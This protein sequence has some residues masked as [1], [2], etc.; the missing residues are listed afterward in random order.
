MVVALFGLVLVAAS[1]VRFVIVYPLP[2]AAGLTG[3]QAA[4]AHGAGPLE[5]V[6]AFAAAVMVSAAALQALREA[7]GASIRWTI[8]AIEGTASCAMAAG[9]VLY[10]LRLLN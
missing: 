10:A 5:T 2:L 7:L 8:R 1:L 3:L 4:L 9:V 6:G